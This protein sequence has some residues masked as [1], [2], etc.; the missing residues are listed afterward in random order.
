MVL[1][2]VLGDTTDGK[3]IIQ[4]DQIQLNGLR[5]LDS[6]VSLSPWSLQVSPHNIG[7][8]ILDLGAAYGTAKSAVGVHSTAVLKPKLLLKSIVP[9]IMAG[10]LGIYGLIV[11]V[12]IMGSSKNFDFV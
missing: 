8:D 10:I 5:S 1:G 9:I 7:N 4:S 11:S 3:Q 12:V 6:W 2:V